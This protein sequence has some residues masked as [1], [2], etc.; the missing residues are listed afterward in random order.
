MYGMTKSKMVWLGYEEQEKELAGYEA[1][2]TVKWCK[3]FETF[4]KLFNT[5]NG[6]RR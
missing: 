2:H 3:G 6:V 4:F 1:G 5:R